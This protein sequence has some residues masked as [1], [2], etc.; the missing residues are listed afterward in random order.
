VKVARRGENGAAI[1]ESVV[2]QVRYGV[3]AVDLC[4][5]RQEVNRTTCEPPAM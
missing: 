3:S 1:T 2:G 4:L 5:F